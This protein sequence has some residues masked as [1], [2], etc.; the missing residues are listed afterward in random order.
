MPT[1]QDILATMDYGPSPESADAAQAWLARHE[2]RFGHF[3][4]GGW[5]AG[6]NHFD[7]VDPASGEVLAAIAQ[8]DAAVV[9]AAVKA[10]QAALPVWRALGGGR[11]RMR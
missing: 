9:D 3:I 1:L 11:A 7:S 2:R 8:G 5:V 10:A 4:N 6:A